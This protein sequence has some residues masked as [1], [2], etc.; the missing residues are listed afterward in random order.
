MTLLELLELI[1][2]G[3]PPKEV[4]FLKQSYKWT[5]FD[6]RN[7]SS[8]RLLSN[9]IS[10]YY[11]LRDMAVDTEM[12][13]CEVEKG[14]GLTNHDKKIIELFNIRYN[15]IISISKQRTSDNMECLVLETPNWYHVLPTKYVPNTRFQK[16]CVN[17]RYTVEE[18]LND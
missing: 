6:Y 10:G 8:R 4:T 14:I 7:M 18:L 2:E 16:M 5:G 12:I 9:E 17:K 1:K 11:D 3:N 13:S 15:D